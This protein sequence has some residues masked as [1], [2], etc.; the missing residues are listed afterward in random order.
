MTTDTAPAEP[1]DVAQLGPRELE[2]ELAVV[3]P[4]FNEAVERQ[5]ALR[6]RRLALVQALRELGLTNV[7]IAEL[8]DTSKGAIEQL[9]HA[10]RRKAEKGT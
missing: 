8:A 10:Q 1:V 4:A 9:L 6:T 3:G 5:K 2:A 7:Q